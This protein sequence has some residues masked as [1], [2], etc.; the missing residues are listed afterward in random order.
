MWPVG[1]VGGLRWEG[2]ICKDGAVVKFY[3]A[4]RPERPMPVDMAGF[5][6]NAKLFI[7]NPEVKM[8]P[9]ANRGYLESSIVSKLAKRD[10]LEPLADNCKQV[11]VAKLNTSVSS[12]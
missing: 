7:D 10:E 6:I 5:A 9:L 2:P 4:W 8:D 11:Y 3:A 12:T 1:L